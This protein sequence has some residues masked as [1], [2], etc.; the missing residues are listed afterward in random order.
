MVLSADGD[1]ICG[2]TWHIVFIVICTVLI[3]PTTVGLPYLIHRT[4]SDAKV[5]ISQADQ[6]KR[7]TLYILTIL[8]TLILCHTPLILHT[9]L[10]L[11]TSILIHI[12]FI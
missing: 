8:T 6:E 5:Y 2:S 10:M 9:P 11:H 3:L 4:I 12:P 7:Y 1:V